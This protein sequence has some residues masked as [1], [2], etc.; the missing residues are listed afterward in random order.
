MHLA[1]LEHLEHLVTHKCGTLG[2]SD[3][4]CF[5]GVAFTRGVLTFWWVMLHLVGLALLY[6]TLL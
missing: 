5:M 3:A 1:R 6:I 4:A 2:L